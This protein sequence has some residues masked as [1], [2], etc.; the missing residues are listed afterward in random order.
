LE[1]YAEP[2]KNGMTST[3][4]KSGD[5]D[6]RRVSV[7]FQD[8]TDRKRREANAAFLIGITEEFSRLSTAAEIMQVVGAKIGAYLKITTCNFTDVDEVAGEVT[9]HY[10]WNSTDV[11][12]TVGTFRITEYL[13]E[14]FE[15]AS[16]AGEDVR[17]S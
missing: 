10:G 13:S 16:R 12:S 14:E 3:F 5:E 2:N 6:S 8:I 11:P 17:D 15:R 7:V 4:S 1:Q 9:V